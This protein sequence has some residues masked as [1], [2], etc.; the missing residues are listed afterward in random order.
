MK[1]F[2][3]Y[4]FIM[5]KAMDQRRSNGSEKE[6]WIREQWIREQWIGMIN[7]SMRG[8]MKV[9]ISYNIFNFDKYN[10]RLLFNTSDRLLKKRWMV[11]A[12]VQGGIDR[13]DK[14]EQAR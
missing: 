12:M 5:M 13:H 9:L 10:I 8:K 6:Q 7:R 11:Q 2:I 14:Q 4:R 3:I 1:S